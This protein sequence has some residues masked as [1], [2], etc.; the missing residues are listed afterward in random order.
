MSRYTGPKCRHCRREG[1]SLCGSAK[2]A[3]KK[4]GYKP[5]M[6]G[7]KGSFSKP[8]EYSRQL[9]EKQKLKRLYGT[10]EKQMRNYY[11]KAS[12]MREIT[13]VALLKELENRLDN[14][15]YKAGFADTR[16]QARQMVSHGHFKIN[17]KRM[18]VP[19][20]QVKAGDKF[21]LVE[22]IKKSPLYAEAEKQKF[23]A[24]AWL[25]VDLKKGQGEVVRL[26]EEEDLDKVI[27]TNLVVEFYSK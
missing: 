8:S 11:D 12:K 9:R 16:A 13:G 25:S 27:H 10:T 6:H 21:E 19:S 7:P 20:Y 23:S 26:V 3:L 2:C 15:I 17:G 5:G 4:K 22:R 1:I 24:P 14:V 18:N